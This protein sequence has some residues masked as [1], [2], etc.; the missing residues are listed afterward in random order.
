MSYQ[1]EL[2]RITYKLRDTQNMY[3]L[4]LYKDCDS[5]N[6]YVIIRNN[7]N[8]NNFFKISYDKQGEIISMEPVEVNCKCIIL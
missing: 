5:Y 4:K 6:E 1:Q 3:H 2:Q 8:F 7:V